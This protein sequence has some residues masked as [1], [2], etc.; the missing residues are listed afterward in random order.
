MN[1]PGGI[2]MSAFSISSTVPRAELNVRQSTRAFSQSSKR[3]R[4][5]KSYFS[6]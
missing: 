1:M 5:K 3:L 2:W 4:A 6:L